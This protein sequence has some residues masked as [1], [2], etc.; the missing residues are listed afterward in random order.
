MLVKLAFIIAFVMQR[1]K[2]CLKNFVMTSKNGGGGGG[3]G[4]EGRQFLDFIFR[5][6]D[7]TDKDQ[8]SIFWVFNFKNLYFLWYW[9]QLLYFWVV[10]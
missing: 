5:L 6:Y 10:K 9:S 2:K 8:R 1:L 3:G 4:G 7:F